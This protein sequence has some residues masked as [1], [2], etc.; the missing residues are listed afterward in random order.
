M[1]KTINIF[2]HRDLNDIIP[3]IIFY[4]LFEGYSLTSIEV[5]L[6]NTE[7]FHGWLSKS[8]LNYYG[9]DTEGSNRGIF[10]NKTIEYIVSMLFQSKNV[11]HNI[12]AKILKNKYL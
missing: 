3:E 10:E 6:F 1:F 4:Y 8:C 5:K 9:I 7:E 11:E 12:V 2:G